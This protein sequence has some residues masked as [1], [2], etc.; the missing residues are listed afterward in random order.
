VNVDGN[1]KLQPPQRWRRYAVLAVLGVGAL[2]VGGRAFQL[3]VVQR[4]FLMQQ[5]DKRQVRV[6]TLPGHRGAIRD[7]RGEPLA[8]SAPVDSIWCVPSE[9][10]ASPEHVA[11]LAKVLKQT[12]RELSKFLDE[13]ASRQFV[14]IERS[15]PPD[16]ARRVLALKAPGVFSTREYRRYYP[17]GE[18]AGQIVGFTDVDGR[19]QE[20][21]EMSQDRKS[22]V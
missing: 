12:P 21:M 19:G 3:Q 14:Y 2:L 1:Y 16:E 9:L 20:G 17:A 8:L 4:E 10:L 15:L 18:I 7:R 13:R 22:V 6:V 5:G 11:A